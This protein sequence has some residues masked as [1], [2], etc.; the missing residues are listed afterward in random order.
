M[1]NLSITGACTYCTVQEDPKHKKSI[2]DEASDEY[3]L[4]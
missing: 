2:L 4:E 3:L 1:R